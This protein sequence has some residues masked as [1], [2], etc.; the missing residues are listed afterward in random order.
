MFKIFLVLPIYSITKIAYTDRLSSLCSI[1]QWDH[2]V[3]LHNTKLQFY[4]IT[5]KGKCKFNYKYQEVINWCNKQKP[6][7]QHYDR[8]SKQEGPKAK[9]ILL[10]QFAVNISKFRLPRVTKYPKAAR[11][12]SQ[13]VL[14]VFI[15]EQLTVTT[16]NIDTVVF[17]TG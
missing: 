14:K 13:I 7:F 1:Q 11:L 12:E 8:T 5:R 6:H 16:Q 9:L 17:S 15:H 4:F 10:L 3:S 2:G